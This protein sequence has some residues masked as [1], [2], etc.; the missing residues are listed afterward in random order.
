M[1]WHCP[2]S[3]FHNLSFRRS[4]LFHSYFDDKRLVTRSYGSKTPPFVG[5][6]KLTS[7]ILV[8]IPK[9]C[10]HRSSLCRVA[11]KMKPGSGQCNSAAIINWTEPHES[12]SMRSYDSRVDHLLREAPSTCFFPTGRYIT[13]RP[14]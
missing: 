2:K 11:I 7:S 9:F 5:S 8:S 3:E 10:I 12:L 4:W 13:A 14:P 1:L 6:Q